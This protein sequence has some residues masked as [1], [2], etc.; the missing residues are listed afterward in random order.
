M[1][2]R[3]A[4]SV[5]AGSGEPFGPVDVVCGMSRYFQQDDKIL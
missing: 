2:W 1:L 3:R 5:D 4:G